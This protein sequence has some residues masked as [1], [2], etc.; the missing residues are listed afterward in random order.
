[1]PDPTYVTRVLRP[2]DQLVEQHSDRLQ[3][4]DIVRMRPMRNGYY[5]L[6]RTEELS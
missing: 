3:R 2:F 1:M 4:A 5:W 6:W